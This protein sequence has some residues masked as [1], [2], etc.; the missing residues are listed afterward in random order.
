MLMGNRVE[1]VDLLARRPARRRVAHGR[2][3]PPHRRRGGLHRRGLRLDRALHRPRARG[4]RARGGRAGARRRWHV[5]VAGPELDAIDAGGRAD[6]FPLD[7]PG[8][9]TM[10]Y[11]SGTTGRPKGVKRE[12]QPSLAP[13]SRWVAR[14][15]MRARARRP[16]PAPRDRPAVPRRPA[17]VRGDRPGQRRRA[18]A[19]AALG[20]GAVPGAHRRA[21]RAQ[22]P[23][24][25]D[26]VRA[27][28]APARRSAAP[29][30]TGRR[31]RPCCT[32]PRRS[33]RR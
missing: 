23:R 28:A 21:G 24:R 2:E 32:A 14:P 7:G 26:D 6:P 31:C 18:G 5:V 29:P 12:R 33:R 4:H 15:G 3:L 9:G 1:L 13:R 16:G 10:L 30:S 8:G 22:Q 11:T 27:P 20:R 25:A 19:H 17:R